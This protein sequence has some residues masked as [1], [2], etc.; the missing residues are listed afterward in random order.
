MKTRLACLIHG[1]AEVYA[2]FRP[3]IKGFIGIGRASRQKNLSMTFPHP[4]N[5]F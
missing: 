1:T 3:L 4:A 5:P 2:P